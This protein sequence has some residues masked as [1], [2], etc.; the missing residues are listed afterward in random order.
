M[1]ESRLPFPARGLAHPV[2]FP[3]PAPGRPAC[4]IDSRELLAYEGNEPFVCERGCRRLPRVAEQEAV[5]S[6]QVVFAL[7]KFYFM[8]LSL[9]KKNFF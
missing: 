8:L 2:P 1:F 4:L 9:S 5:T 6:L 3:S 7:Q